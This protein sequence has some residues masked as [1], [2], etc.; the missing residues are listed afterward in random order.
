[1]L[2]VLVIVSAGLFGWAVF[3][4][5]YTSKI[6]VEEQYLN[7]RETHLE[8]LKN[9][10][11]ETGTYPEKA[12]EFEHA[13]SQ[14]NEALKQVKKNSNY[15]GTLKIDLAISIMSE[16][17]SAPVVDNRKLVQ[18]VQIVRDVALNKNYDAQTRNRAFN[19][20]GDFLYNHYDGRLPAI[21]RDIVFIG[22]I[23]EDLLKKDDIGFLPAI[24]RVYEVAADT[25]PYPLSEYRAANTFADVLL[26]N[27]NLSK[28]EQLSLLNTIREH[29]R[30]GD[31]L[32]KNP[33]I[34]RT[35][36]AL[37]G[38]AGE[39]LLAKHNEG[40]SHW[41]RA[42]TLA[43][44]Y[45][46]NTKSKESEKDDINQSFE[47]ALQILSSTRTNIASRYEMVSRYYYAFWLVE[48]YGVERAS[49]IQ[50]LLRP[51]YPSLARASVDLLEFI[52]AEAD[53]NIHGNHYHRRGIIKLAAI[54]P[55]WRAWVKGNGWT[56]AL[57]NVTLPPLPLIAQ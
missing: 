43:R 5:F 6:A 21:A 16:G 25:F 36:G 32:M 30:R 49:Q 3:R 46:T 52:L 51:I 26:S 41:L 24:A 12:A 22:P 4:Y 8:A 38:P 35:S 15:E 56:D 10:Q 29:L 17:M 34:F 31:E 13:T 19:R 50:S 42:A 11:S 48:A 18:A 1:M 57:L 20:L 2:I 47:K 23:F 14:L 55:E 40:N 44:L 53:E 37:E 39:D 9:M 28:A 33:S 54:D 45:L 27:Q 7:L